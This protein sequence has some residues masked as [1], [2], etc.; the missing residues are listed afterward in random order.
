MSKIDDLK[1]KWRKHTLSWEDMGWLFD[2]IEELDNLFEIQR[3]R[4]DKATKLWQ[5][6]TGRGETLPD[7]GELLGWLMD[8]ADRLQEQLWDE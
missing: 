3:T 7:L 2:R 1:A 6:A 5:K 4:M 8:H